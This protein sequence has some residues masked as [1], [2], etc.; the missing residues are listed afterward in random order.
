MET[1]AELR[2]KKKVEE[3]LR[4]KMKAK[5]LKECDDVLS[6]FTECARGRTLSVVWACREQHKEMNDCLKQFTNDEVFEE[7]K[8]QYVMETEGK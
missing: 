2:M 1:M 5:A 8:R 4:S 3:A 6:K 7:Q